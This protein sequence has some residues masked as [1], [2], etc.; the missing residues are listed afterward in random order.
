MYVRSSCDADS[1]RASKRAIISSI[2]SS[3]SALAWKSLGQVVIGTFSAS[4]YGHMAASTYL[5][6]FVPFCSER[7]L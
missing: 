1:S 4:S 5:S 6:I 3:D 7:F 2:A